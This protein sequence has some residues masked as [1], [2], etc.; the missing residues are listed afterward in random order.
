MI[1]NNPDTSAR[2]LEKDD[3]ISFSLFIEI[4]KKYA[5]HELLP[6]LIIRL[7]QFAIL[8]NSFFLNLLQE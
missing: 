6:H 7:Y 4:E 2:H 3:D 8:V 1:N 5:E